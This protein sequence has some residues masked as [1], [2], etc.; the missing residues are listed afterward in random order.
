[1]RHY[2]ETDQIPIGVLSDVNRHAPIPCEN[3][4]TNYE[5][6]VRVILIGG[7]RVD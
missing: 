3:C 6:N 5:A 1:M 2:S 7:K 4:S